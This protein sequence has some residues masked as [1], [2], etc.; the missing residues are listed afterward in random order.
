VVGVGDANAQPG[1]RLQAANGMTNANGE[2]SN[3]N[4][5]YEFINEVVAW[6]NG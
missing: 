3:I 2:Q 4:R 6:P 5:D 1:V